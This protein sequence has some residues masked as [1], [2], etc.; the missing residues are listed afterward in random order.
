M[1]LNV[2]KSLFQRDIANYGHE[3][4]SLLLRPSGQFRA[5]VIIVTHRRSLR[6]STT[7]AGQVLFNGQR[8]VTQRSFRNAATLSGDAVA[9]VIAD[10]Y[11]HLREHLKVFVVGCEVG[12]TTSNIQ[13]RAPPLAV[14]DDAGHGDGLGGH[15]AQLPVGLVAQ[16]SISGRMLVAGRGSSEGEAVGMQGLTDTGHIEV[17]TTISEPLTASLHRNLHRSGSILQSTS[18]HQV[19][20][21]LSSLG[22]SIG[23]NGAAVVNDNGQAI[24]VSN[25]QLT[26]D[27][28]RVGVLPVV[29]Q[30]QTG[31]AVGHLGMHPRQTKDASI[32]ADSLLNGITSSGGTQLVG[33]SNSASGRHR[34]VVG[35]VLPLVPR[36]SGVVLDAENTVQ[37]LQ[38]DAL[39]LLLPVLRYLGSN[40]THGVSAGVEV[41]HEVL[42]LPGVSTAKHDAALRGT[43]GSGHGD[44]GITI[45]VVGSA[46]QHV[47]ERQSVHIGA[48]RDQAAENTVSLNGTR[49]EHSGQRR[50]LSSLPI[51]QKQ[52]RV[53]RVTQIRARHI[54]LPPFKF[55]V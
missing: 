33:L 48:V 23:G 32:I 2:R 40:L 3:L 20:S 11:S 34:D 5:L 17:V 19:R 26:L 15:A 7:V 41:M 12:L 29:Q 45:I 52:F 55:L 30:L 9:A 53:K 39:T 21:V 8:L 16:L 36:V 1:R 4:T 35:V 18:T 27:A 28:L 31:Q 47:V 25:G 43:I 13:H 37:N 22:S 24:E 6:L 54:D 46:T 10:G 50:V 38:H 44:V 49:V 14:G 42:V 51:K